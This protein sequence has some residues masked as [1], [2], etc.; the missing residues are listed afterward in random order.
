MIARGVGKVR[1]MLEH[2]E[3]QEKEAVA[4]PGGVAQEEPVS[5]RAPLMEAVTMAPTQLA[6]RGREQGDRASTSF[7][8]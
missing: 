1:G 2:P 4:H 5:G 6:A 8:L 7:C 3:S